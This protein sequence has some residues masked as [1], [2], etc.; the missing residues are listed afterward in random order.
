MDGTKDSTYAV[1][2]FHTKMQPSAPTLIICLL[3]GL[4]VTL[5]MVPLC[6]TPSARRALF[7]ASHMH[8]RW[9]EPPVA[10]KRPQLDTHM[11]VGSE[12]PWGLLVTSTGFACARSQNEIRLS[13]PTEKKPEESGWMV[14]PLMTPMRCS[15]VV[16]GLRVDECEQMAEI[17]CIWAATR[18]SRRKSHVRMALHNQVMRCSICNNTEMPALTCLCCTKERE[19]HRVTGRCQ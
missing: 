17:T 15:T 18:F 14:T 4:N 8:T 13:W 11:Q 16:E 6:P 19:S 5:V 12:S 7:V 9:S 10:R 1:K 3:S 2:T